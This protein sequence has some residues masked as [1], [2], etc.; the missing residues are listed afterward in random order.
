[1]ENFLTKRIKKETHA[2]VRLFVSKIKSTKK[3]ATETELF[4]LSDAAGMPL[5]LVYAVVPQI[6]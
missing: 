3:T 5:Q 6:L 2:R 4:W 1:M